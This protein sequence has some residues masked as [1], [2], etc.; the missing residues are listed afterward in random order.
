MSEPDA[1]EPEPSRDGGWKKLHP[2]SV[3]V[4]L[5]PRTWILLRQVW[6]LMVGWF[7]LGRVSGQALVDLG[8]L[9]MFLSPAV[10]GTVLH[11]ALL[12]YR[13]VGHH[14]EVETGLLNRQTRLIAVDRVQNVE[15]VRTVFHRIFGLVEVRIET[16]S[17]K[18]VEGLLSALSVE[19]ADA[20]LAFLE[21]GR[22]QAT[23]TEGPQEQAPATQV[24]VDASVI[25][26][27][28]FGATGTRLA[29]VAVL[30]GFVYEGVMG[31]GTTPDQIGGARNLSRELAPVL[32]VAVVTGAWWLGVGS[33]IGRFYGYR[34]TRQGDALVSE[35]GLFTRRAARLGLTKIQTLSFVE[36]FLR[37]RLG[38][39]SIAIETASARQEGDG[40]ER[41]ETVVPYVEHGDAT[42]VLRAALPELPE[43]DGLQLL[44]AHP[45]AARRAVARAVVGGLFTT[46]LAVAVLGPVGS[47]TLVI[48]PIGAIGAWLDVRSQGYLV[49]GA[50]AVSRRG[51]WTRATMVLPLRKVQS[52]DLRQGPWL[53]R[54]GLAELVVRVAGSRVALP[55]QELAEAE[56]TR[57]EILRAIP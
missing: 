56:R 30:L 12:R 22:A 28:W 4:N 47:L 36:P 25:D 40:M 37:R 44:P 51:Y 8:V 21:R 17:G 29:S 7:V 46:L 41:A 16:A 54:R 24:V 57:D 14:L 5:I 20:L 1:P 19:D 42:R 26:L 32:L 10:V 3:G 15:L 52:V 27:L 45:W 31:P 23:R 9:A 33:A 38:F 6:P 55:V 35:Q 50:L 43:L 2:L 49:D 11:W 18:E 39:G 53:R 48:L 13:M 34:L